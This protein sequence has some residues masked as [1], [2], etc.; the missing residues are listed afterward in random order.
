[1]FSKTI[2]G[3][4][5]SNLE[6]LGKEKKL[7]QFYLAGGTAIALQLGHRISR[8]LDFFT[9]KDFDEKAIVADLEK[10]GDIE[11][12]ILKKETVL[13]TFSSVKISLF[14]YRYPLIASTTPWLGINIAGINDLGCMKL[15]AI[16]SRGTKRDFIDLWAIL[17]S[18]LNLK[19]LFELFEKKYSGVKYNKSHLLRSLT[20]FADAEKDD[21][22]E[23]LKPVF[24]NDIKK[25]LENEA[26]KF[27]K[28][29]I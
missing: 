14:F 7:A 6:L 22:P 29:L 4:L 8:D 16:Q 24:W 23:M 25:F 20:Y 21:M 5:Q 26:K 18:G 13:G 1:M 9:D 17:Q 27:L 3:K 2:P 28:E 12:D 19:K 15:D 10:I 11:I